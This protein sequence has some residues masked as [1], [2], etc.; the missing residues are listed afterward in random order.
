LRALVLRALVARR[1]PLS[2]I[3]SCNLAIPE[4]RKSHGPFPVMCKQLWEIIT[5]GVMLCRFI[6]QFLFK[7]IDVICGSL[8]S[9]C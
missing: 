3:G 1:Y 4:P 7:K 8:I 6:Y 2:E 5:I 9:L